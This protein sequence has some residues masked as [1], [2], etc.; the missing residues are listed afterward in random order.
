MKKSELSHNKSDLSDFYTLA[1]T[2][3]GKAFD[4]FY[5]SYAT[6]CNR[7]SV[8][9]KQRKGKEEAKN[10]LWFD[11][12]PQKRRRKRKKNMGKE[13]KSA[14][15]FQV[16]F[17]GGWIEESEM[18]RG[19]KVTPNKKSIKILVRMS[20]LHLISRTTLYKIMF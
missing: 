8:I 1:P 13:N 10:I 20:E 18:W 15:F 11:I 2:T 19:G 17:G 4:F 7:A 16:L 3:F 6:I 14:I 12:F 5:S 9:I